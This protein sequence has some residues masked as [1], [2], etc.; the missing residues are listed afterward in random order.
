[1]KYENV[2][3]L[4]D[5]K[6]DKTANIKLTKTDKSKAAKFASFTD[7]ASESSLKAE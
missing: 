2:S 5:I 3:L 4:M 1:M 6:G 7:G